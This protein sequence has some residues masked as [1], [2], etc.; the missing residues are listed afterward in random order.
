MYLSGS[1]EAMSDPQDNESPPIAG[2]ADAPAEPAAAPE[3]D[4]PEA[5][6]ALLE[7]EK[8]EARERML[9]VAADF[10]NW[11]KRARKEVIEAELKGKER[12]LKDFLEV[13]DNLERAASASA[14]GAQAAAI[15]DGVRLVLRL[16]QSKFDR[17]E[18][19]AVEALG[20]PF[21]PHLH[22]AVARVPTA[23]A[24]AGQVVQELVRGYLLGDRLLR[25]AAVAVAVPPAVSEAA[26]ASGES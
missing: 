26:P 8:A 11:K 6:I 1:P 23:D 16:F 24:P 22:E 20:R 19:K 21:D 14:E 10:E 3:P 7:K 9:R 25:P 17:H 15:L 12:V 18:V 5:R 2:P 4:T 13:V